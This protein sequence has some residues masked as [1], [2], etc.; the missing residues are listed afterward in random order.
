M[1]D[2]T[3]PSTFPNAFMPNMTF[4]FDSFLIEDIHT[5]DEGVTEHLLPLI[6]N[7]NDW[8]IIIAHF[9]GV[10]H[11]GH[12][13]GSDHPAMHTK[14]VQMNNV[15]S[16]VVNHMDSNTLLVV[17]GDH[18]MEL[19]GN[20]GGDGALETSPGAWIYSKG[21]S[22]FSYNKSSLATPSFNT[23][24]IPNTLTPTT[25][26]PGAAYPYR[27][28][29]QIDLL[30]TISLLLGLPIPFNNLGT[31]V[32]EAFATDELIHA[33]LE[34][35][36][37]QIHNLI[38]AYRESDLGKD[39][40]ISWDSLQLLWET[41]ERASYG[42]TDRLEALYQYNRLALSAYRNAWNIF[43]VVHM[44]LGLVILTTAALSTWYV[45]HHLEVYHD[46]WEEYISNTLSGA[47]RSGGVGLVVAIGTQT[48]VLG[49][50]WTQELG[51]IHWI[52]L[53]TSLTSSM[54]VLLAA[55]SRSR[56]PKP[57]IAVV[58]L[59]THVISV[60]FGVLIVWE[61]RVV[62]LLLLLS[63]LPIIVSAMASPLIHLRNRTIGFSILYAIAIYLSSWSRVCREEQG[64][65]CQTTFYTSESFPVA[66]K[67]VLFAIFPTALAVVWVSKQFLIISNSRK[68]A[69]GFIFPYIFAP[70]L[71]LGSAFWMVEY[72]E[73]QEFFGVKY[74]PH[75]RTLRTRISRC[76]LSLVLGG[77]LWVWWTIPVTMRISSIL[78]ADSVERRKFK[79][80]ATDSSNIYGAPFFILW[81][82]A[83][84]FV[85]PFVQLT[86]QI[87]LALSVVAIL[88][89]VE[90]VGGT[91]ALIRV[92]DTVKV[93]HVI[94]SIS[95]Q[96]S[97]NQSN[98][99][100]W[101]SIAFFEVFPFALIGMHLFFGTGHQTTAYSIQWKAAYV[102]S[103]AIVHP[104]TPISVILNSFAGQLLLGLAA[105][106]LATWNTFPTFSLSISHDL[107]VV[108]LKRIQ[109]EAF[110]ALLAYQLYY[111][112]LLASALA[113]AVLF[114]RDVA[115]WKTWAPRVGV[116]IG[117]YIIA[118]LA[119]VLAWAL[120]V[121]RIT[122]A[123]MMKIP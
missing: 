48:L 103:S 49:H 76:A 63:T 65:A 110:R 95:S 59:A 119:G 54:G 75:L 96:F 5:V 20:H 17:L 30:P 80:T 37:Q 66:P 8:D 69:T 31:I 106:L 51:L 116:A 121:S 7:S 19:S 40:E 82:F 112:I 14:L 2:D 72:A 42:T 55:P 117:S 15:L 93:N 88:A 71:F 47:I 92:K 79:R 44:I 52:W 118:S 61:E 32:P 41:I 97:N 87:S 86:G 90:A 78:D 115:V 64:S 39:L 1:G 104:W 34:I 108:A 105:P 113:S 28:I 68:H 101:N 74:G 123:K 50:K 58:P 56:L 83:F 4:P 70:A 98:K 99:K 81:L 62:S 3:W 11:V 89:Y 46:S 53:N 21:A 114:R 85:W 120:G 9:L 22:F 18:G 57:S 60:F 36:S 91:R 23:S 24:I 26:F 109:R 100:Q 27:H 29:Q 25:S 13:L 122:E 67:F 38:E 35:N 33:A 84:T 111:S 16:Y 102:L 73:T 94:H 43:N 12:R 45:Y 107:H 77:G 10:D 6:N